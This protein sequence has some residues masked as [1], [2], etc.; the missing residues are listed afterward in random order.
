MS[1][2]RYEAPKTLDA[3]VA[4]LAGAQGL[5]KV[6]AGGS[7]L[8]V[9][10]KSGRF[11]GALIVT[12]GG[13]V[14]TEMLVVLLVAAEWLPAVSLAAPAATVIP[15]LP[16]PLNAFSVTVKGLAPLTPATVAPAVPVTMIWLVL[17]VGL[18]LRS[19]SE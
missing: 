9:Q 1:E 16:L 7:D 14:S 6:L 2:L 12:T 18:A 15:T 8:L 11:D 19:G 13:V 10:M 5:T 3:A 4:L 17:N